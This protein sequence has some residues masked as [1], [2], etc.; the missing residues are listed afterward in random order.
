MQFQ[1]QN[2]DAETIQI[3]LDPTFEN[4][5]I[6]NGLRHHFVRVYNGKRNRVCPLHLVVDEE[7]NVYETLYIYNYQIIDNANIILHLRSIPDMLIV[8]NSYILNTVNFR[9]DIM[10]DEKYKL[11]IEDITDDN[12]ITIKVKK[13]STADSFVWNCTERINF[14]GEFVTVTCKTESESTDTYYLDIHSIIEGQDEYSLSCTT[15]FD[16]ESILSS[17]NSIYLTL[18]LLKFADSTELNC[19]HHFYDIDISRTPQVIEPKPRNQISYTVIFETESI[20]DSLK[21]YNNRFEVFI[22]D[23]TLGTN[24]KKYS[25]FTVDLIIYPSQY[26]NDIE[27]DIQ[28]FQTGSNSLLLHTDDLKPMEFTSHKVKYDERKKN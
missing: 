20:Y 28:F 4:F 22:K 15:Y 14:Y 3:L 6:I 13:T 19:Y 1:L 26:P 27:L 9:Y 17:V 7:S 24:Y 10:T 25:K 2:I 5:D 18:P 16:H 8:G 23:F 11:E 12:K 21:N